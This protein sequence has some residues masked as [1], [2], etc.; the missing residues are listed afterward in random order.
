MEKQIVEIMNTWVEDWNERTDDLTSS[1]TL[2]PIYCPQTGVAPLDRARFEHFLRSR[3]A[4]RSKL[5]VLILTQ[6]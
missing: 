5:F 6:Y 1:T 4:R 2:T 3:R